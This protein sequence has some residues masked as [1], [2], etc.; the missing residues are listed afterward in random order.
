MRNKK[1]CH[2]LMIALSI[3]VFLQTVSVAEEGEIPE[4]DIFHEA[5]T[6]EIVPYTPPKDLKYGIMDS[7]L[8]PIAYSG[9]EKLRYEVS[10]TGGIKLGEV[11]FEIRRAEDAL[12]AYELY[13][14]V[15]TEDTFFNRIYPVRDVYLTKVKGEER[16]PYH[17]EVWQKEGREYEAHRLTQYDQDSGVIRYQKNKDEPKEYT[18]VRPTH[19]EFSSFFSS[20]LMDFE[21]GKSFL[22]PTFAD[23]KNKD[24]VVNIIKKERIKKTPLGSVR[25]V[26]VS[27]IL[28]FKGI[29]DKQG[30]TTIWYTDDEC[31]VPVKI[32]SKVAI[33]SLTAKL[34]S[35]ENPACTRYTPLAKAAP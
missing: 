20:R 29:Y 28:E 3:F 8:V 31:R 34:M 15:T 30:D 9:R 10:Y 35:Y 21:V 14:L 5:P 22:V 25:T 18:M 13:A 1:Y 24:V 16:L 4:D 7:S 12:D 27:P 32:T 33:G 19:N 6:V 26:Q 2:I 17:Y 23:K 11:F